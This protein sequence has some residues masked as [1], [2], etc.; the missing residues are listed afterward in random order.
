MKIERMETGVPGLDEMIMGGFPIPSAILVGGEPGTGK[1]TLVVQSLFHGARNGDT[2][3]Y[4][5]VIAE[6]QW[7]VQKFLSTFNFYDQKLVDKE[8]MNFVDISKVIV[9]KPGSLLGT[10]K[11]IVEKYSPNRIAIDPITPIKH[12]IEKKVDARRF[13]HTLLAYLKAFNCVTL[14][15]NEMDYRDLSRSLESYMVDGVLM[16]SYPEEERVRRKYLEVLKMRGTKHVTGKQLV[17]ITEE[18]F[19]VQRGLR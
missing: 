11:K 10:I 4:I 3:L 12:A 17:D 16:L 5:T 18:G 7:V 14:I 6:P 13:V 2:C 15:T 19:I 9:D 1:T 8:K